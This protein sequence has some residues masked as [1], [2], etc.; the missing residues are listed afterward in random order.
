MTAG[1]GTRMTVGE[2][3]RMTVGEG[4][5]MT[6]GEGLG[7]VTIFSHSPIKTT[8]YACYKKVPFFATVFLLLSIKNRKQINYIKIKILF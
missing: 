4:T 5:R 6:A 7:T 3:T 8:C 1:E 2:G